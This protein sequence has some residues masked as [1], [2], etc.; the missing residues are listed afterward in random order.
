MEDIIL[1]FDKSVFDNPDID[2]QEKTPL[3]RSLESDSKENPQTA[4][5]IIGLEN[6][7]NLILVEAEV[8]SAFLLQPADY[9]EATGADPVTKSILDGVKKYFPKLD[10]CQEYKAYQGIIISK[11]CGGIPKFD[12]SEI[13]DY[14]KMGKILGYPC[15]DEFEEIIRNKDIIKYGV[16]VYVI[17]DSHPR[18]QLMANVCK[19]K[20]K[21]DI[22]KNFAEK[23]RHALRRE[24]NKLLEDIKILDII[25]D[26][27]VTIPDQVIIDRLSDVKSQSLSEDEEDTVNNILYN[28]ISEEFS[29][30]FSKSVRYNNEYHKGITAFIVLYNKNF[31]L[32]PF[33][34]FQFVEGLD[35]EM[36]VINENWKTKILTLLEETSD[37]SAANI[38]LELAFE[39]VFKDTRFSELLRQTSQKGNKFHKG[40]IRS[41]V[42]FD[43]IFVLSRQLKDANV[44]RIEEM[45]EKIEELKDGILDVLNSSKKSNCFNCSI[46]GGKRKTNRNRK[47]KTIR[48]KRSYKKKTH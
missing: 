6:L 9:S 30:V 47:N 36:S 14:N 27:D 26:T 24:H 25:V 38:E 13:I 21:I 48:K 4:L 1:D 37:E 44:E 46:S 11:N 18:I 3:L 40:L 45:G 28:S 12:P 29:E 35:G 17:F 39:N 19:D 33:I 8:R 31:I 41:M 22:F 15:S 7:L 5:R 10:L 34:P 16:Y 2:K 20:S 32:N 42:I 43:S 23:A